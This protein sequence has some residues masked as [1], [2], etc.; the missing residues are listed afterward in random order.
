MAFFSKG[1]T[2]PYCFEV[3]RL[4]D[5]P[6]RC[7]N[8]RCEQEVDAVRERTWRDSSRVGRV[9]PPVGFSPS[10]LRCGDCGEKSR[11][12]VCPH[13]HMELPRTI[14]QFRNLIF[15]IIGAKASGKSHYIAVLIE[16]LRQQVGPALQILL[17]PVNDA[18]IKRYKD[19][20]YN[21]LYQPRDGQ[22]R[23]LDGT[24]SAFQNASKASYPMVY[25]L[26][27]QGR[28]LLGKKKIIA[29]VTLTFF[30]TAGEDLNDE[31]RMATVNKYI[32][33]SDGLILLFD[34]LQIQPVRDRLPQHLMPSIHTES[35]EILERTTNLIQQGRNLPPNRMIDT[36]LAIAFSKLD[37]LAP[38]I[39]PGMQIACDSNHLG[40]F[41]LA[42]SKAVDSELQALLSS[43]RCNDLIGQVEGR[44][45]RHNFFALSA[46]GTQPD[47]DGFLPRIL[48]R[49]VEDPFLWLLYCHG[50]LKARPTR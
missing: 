21:P 36:P 1:E 5:T 2:C 9:L 8:E 6:F 29:V 39:E 11:Q 42:D 38:L 46:L 41:D 49:R 50:L 44:Y 23:T 40:G 4:N 26:S 22:R 16:Q 34:P 12:R 18:T 43:W 48:P 20:F 19:D 32:Y 17:E 47:K 37:A 25:A 45:S 24:A 28:S 30:D 10:E 3:F 14:G 27:I 15:A 7:T 31:N 33:K 35:R 13:C